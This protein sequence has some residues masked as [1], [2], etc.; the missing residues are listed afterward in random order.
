MP[1]QDQID[2]YH[3]IHL[4]FGC[5]ASLNYMIKCLSRTNGSTDDSEI[6][7]ITINPS[8]DVTL[9]DFKS[10]V[11]SM[12]TR[13]FMKN[14]TTCFEQR[15]KDEKHQGTGIHAHIIVDKVAHYS[16]KQVQTRLYNSFK[17]MC[18]NSNHIDVRKYP[19]SYKSDKIAYMKGDKW[20][21]DKEAAVKIN[22][23]W[24]EKNNIESLYI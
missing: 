9:E 14:M 8:S 13:P 12:K 4:E 1:T 11:L 18:G 5:I 7:F 16:P 22:L 10:K 17:H 20:D 23:R 2:Q 21:A 19:A 24:R 3:R 6:Y 15:G